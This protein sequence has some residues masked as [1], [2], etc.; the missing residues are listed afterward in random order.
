MQSK[1]EVG[2]VIERRQLRAFGGVYYASY[3]I[4]E[5]HPHKFLARP[6]GSSLEDEIMWFANDMRGQTWV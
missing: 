3:I 1:I 2:A 6:L 4:Q 5:V